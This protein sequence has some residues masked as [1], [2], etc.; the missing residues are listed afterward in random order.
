M[1]E[2]LSLQQQN[3]LKSFPQALDVNSD[4]L[5]EIVQK[6]AVTGT[7]VDPETLAG[8]PAL[9]RQFLDN[10]VSQLSYSSQAM[11]FFSKLPKLKSASTVVEYTTFDRHGETGHSMFDTEVG[12]SAPS[13]PAM[14]RRLVRTKNLSATRSVSLIS[15]AVD[16]IAQPVQI[17]TDDAIVSV[18][19]GIEWASFY[20]DKSLTD[21]VQDNMGGG[22]GLE[23][24]GLTQQIDPNNVI[25]ARGADLTPELLN[26]ACL[27]VAKGY[28]T[29]TDAFM[30]LGVLSKFSTSFIPNARYFSNGIGGQNTNSVTAGLNVTQWSSTISQIE[31]NGSAVM[32]NDKFLDTQFLGGQNAPE[33]P[34]V[35]TPTVKETDNAKFTTSD[36]GTVSYRVT[37]W[38][39]Q[40][41]SVYT[42]VNAALD[43]V[44][45]SISLAI[46]VPATYTAT[47][48][49]ASIY[50]LDNAS[51][52]YYL[53]NRVGVNQA[54]NGVITFV[55]RNE[56]IPATVD[57]FV[58]EVNN[59]TIRLYELLPL[60]SLPLPTQ[61]K[62]LAWSVIWNGALALIAPKRFARI[63]NVGY[64]PAVPQF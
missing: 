34:A 58:G 47:P 55:D 28:G 27:Y 31:L 26:T 62:T 36:I 40:A 8:V 41:Q 38:S 20:G 53:I 50:R 39:D 59:L 4:G 37:L 12:L 13:D 61:N 33:A 23:F 48:K 5:N 43:K 51:G 57:V 18:V 1:S 17:Y 19:K 9:R 44:D 46:T 49:F 15:Q 63:K 60:M 52:Q 30:P 24:N 11:V 54:V 56:N 21:E 2:K 6:A 10:R 32:E 14:H 29:P 64:T 16:N 42:E 25:D 45:S 35:A 3:A 22:E 7:D